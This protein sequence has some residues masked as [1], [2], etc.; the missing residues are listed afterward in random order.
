MGAG[1][2]NAMTKPT[3]K[4][5]LE[6]CEVRIVHLRRNIALWREEVRRN[7]EAYVREVRRQRDELGLKP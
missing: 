6:A 5:R 7:N 3:I 2:Q 4:D 1:I